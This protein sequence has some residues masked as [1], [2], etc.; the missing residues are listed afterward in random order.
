MMSHDGP[1]IFLSYSHNDREVVKNI[2]RLL[3][4]EGVRVTWDQEFQIGDPWSGQMRECLKAADCVV[5][6]WSRAAVKSDIV[7]HEFTI[8]D[9][10]NKQIGIALESNITFP[11]IAGDAHHERYYEWDQDN[12]QDRVKAL[13]RRIQAVVALR[14]PPVSKA[15]IVAFVR[16]VDRS[17]QEGIVRQTLNDNISANSPSFV[18][19]LSANSFDRPEEFV[20]RVA[21]EALPEMLKE[22][23]IIASENDESYEHEIFSLKWPE[24]Y[25]GV[26]EAVSSIIKNLAS[27]I[28]D[29]VSNEAIEFDACIQA[30]SSIAP[31]IYIELPL[32]NW[33]D[34]DVS[35]VNSLLGRFAEIG[36]HHANPKYCAIFIV[37]KF[38]RDSECRVADRSTG[39]FR[40]LIGGRRDIDDIFES[41]ASNTTRS[42]LLPRLSKI[43]RRHVE[44]WHDECNEEYG[45]PEDRDNYF[46][47]KI[48]AHYKES[49]SQEEHYQFVARPLQEALEETY[50]RVNE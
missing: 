48:Y 41:L 8:A 11:G 27:K 14:N 12:R 2:K 13:A 36:F 33:Q 23:G 49:D 29:D 26:D 15:E 32:A 35:V 40:R 31:T 46:C 20:K 34:T 50:L 37:A 45:I 22:K 42:K 7:K 21:N 38:E 9:Y 18:W 25:R 24:G 10:E 30:T 44:A 5:I 1:Q 4:S 47:E 39:I 6:C 17:D 28:Y 16:R 43:S 19:L 3:E